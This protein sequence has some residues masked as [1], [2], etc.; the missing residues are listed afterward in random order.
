MLLLL[1]LITRY[2]VNQFIRNLIYL[3]DLIYIYILLTF[4]IFFSNCRSSVRWRT[5]DELRR[6]SR[7]LMEMFL[8]LFLSIMEM[9]RLVTNH[10]VYCGF[11]IIHILFPTF[12]IS[13]FSWLKHQNVETQ[14]NMRKPRGHQTLLCVCAWHGWLLD[15]YVVKHQW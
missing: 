5:G 1:L 4:C 2:I 11:I 15:G 10:Y 3:K 8:I 13:S 14:S 6:S 7:R 9:I 12:F